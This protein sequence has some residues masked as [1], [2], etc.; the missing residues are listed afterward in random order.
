MD[1]KI[2]NKVNETTFLGLLIQQN[3]KWNEHI[4]LLT[5]KINKYSSIIFLI[6]NSLDNNSLKLI[7][8]TLIYSNL[9]YA[10]VI[11]GNSP[12]KHIKPLVT[13]QK[14]VLRT[15][16]FRDRFHHTNVDFYNL[17]IL[18]LADINKYFASIFTY[19]SLNYLTYPVEYF[20][21]V[22]ATNA[23][24]LRNADNLRPPLLGSSQS[25]RSPSYY[26]VDIW[27]DIPQEIK[28]KPSVAS[29][30]FA[31]KNLLIESYNL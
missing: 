18:K 24:A 17:R 30:K 2:I 5:N 1:N 11:W 12:Q 8:N 14:K 27:N 22:S 13:A 31:M 10:N 19:K 20:S 6:R 7:Y 3:L 25:Q 9:V 15:I 4:K 21:S 28:S 26:C 29:F 16:K 23:Y